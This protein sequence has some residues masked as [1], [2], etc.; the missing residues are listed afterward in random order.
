[1]VINT[2]TD[3]DVTHVGIGLTFGLIVMSMIYSIGDIS[4]AH[5]NPAVT[6]AFFVSKR[7]SLGK[8]FPY[9]IAQCI[10]AILASALL[11]FL[12][13][14]VG[15]LGATLPAYATSQSFILEVILTFFL[16]FVIL[17]VSTG[18][19]EKGIMAGAA[20]GSVVA[21]EAI[22]AGP[23]TGASM[24]P[25]RSLAPAIVSGNVTDLWVYLVAPVL[26]AVL[27]VP[28]FLFIQPSDIHP[29]DEEPESVD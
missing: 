12:F 24:N 17:N 3:G 10:G 21:L 14:N 15:N 4:G 7:F 16:M 9:I 13:S 27:A 5:M 22:F 19:K 6:I 18:A 2:V 1:M 20:I 11:R 26:G 25:A 28:A 29:S 8:V 23:I